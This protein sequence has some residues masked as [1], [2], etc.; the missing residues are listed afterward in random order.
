MCF[1]WV[2]LGTTQTR[3]A[4][5]ANH[6][7]PIL[8]DP[9]GKPVYQS[10]VWVCGWIVVCHGVIVRVV[11]CHGLEGSKS[12]HWGA[13]A[14]R[15]GHNEHWGARASSVC[16]GGHSHSKIAIRSGIHRWEHRARVPID[17]ATQR[18]KGRIHGTTVDRVV[19]W[20]RERERWDR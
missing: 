17:L 15:C 8:A 19:N 14:G 9:M 10:C 1:P 11:A 20:V 4:I 7:F 6:Y 5:T 3:S 18:E 13:I 12:G 2:A 16:R